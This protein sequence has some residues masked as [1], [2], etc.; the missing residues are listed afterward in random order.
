MSWPA[1][2]TVSATSS[3][4]EASRA[5]AS[6]AEQAEISPRRQETSF[7]FTV[8]CFSSFLFQ[9]QFSVLNSNSNLVS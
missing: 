3:G 6:W 4:S 8:F 7:L 5:C 9:F 1:G 2:P